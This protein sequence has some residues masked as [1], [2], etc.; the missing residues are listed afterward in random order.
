MSRV[1]PLGTTVFSARRN[2]VWP[3]RASWELNCE[4]Q[5]VSVGHNAEFAAGGADIGTVVNPDGAVGPLPAGAARQEV[6]QSE[7][8]EFV[9]RIG[10]E[11]HISRWHRIQCR[12]LT[13]G[14]PTSAY[15]LETEKTQLPIGR[16]AANV[17]NTRA[18]YARSRRLVDN[19]LS[20][21]RAPTMKGGWG[22]S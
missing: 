13:N 4:Q 12:S 8:V 14:R 22:N 18:N 21:R 6:I 2:V 1:P 3:V 19:Q 20:R 16:L 15:L 11:N 17:R 5:F 10:G 7:M 9:A